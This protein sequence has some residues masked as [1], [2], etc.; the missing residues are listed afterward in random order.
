[1]DQSFVKHTLPGFYESDT[2]VVPQ[3]D[4]QIERLSEKLT[5]LVITG[6]CV[7]TKAISSISR[8]EGLQDF[9]LTIDRRNSTIPKS[10]VL[11]FPSLLKLHLLADTEGE[12]RKCDSIVSSLHAPRLLDLQIDYHFVLSSINIS[13]ETLFLALSKPS[14]AP[15]L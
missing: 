5:T 6:I 1:V 10:T 8:L 13:L 2:P 3:F 9:T 14:V 7:S 12:E 11:A 4:T 15:S